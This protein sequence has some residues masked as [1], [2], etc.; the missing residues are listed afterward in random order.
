MTPT[1]ST[2]RPTGRPAGRGADRGTGRNVALGV[3]L[4][5]CAAAVVAHVAVLRTSGQD[6]VT[7]PIGLLSTAPAGAWHGAGI[8]AFALAHLAL[9]WLL[10]LRSTGPLRIAARVAL[11]LAA[12][13][14]CYVAAYFAFADPAAFA[15]PGADDRL[16]VPASLVG[17]AMGLLLPG[18]WRTHRR[19]AWFGG[20]CFAAWMALTAL[21][22]L[23]DPS[24]IGAYE[25]A[26]GAVYVTWVAGMA[27]LV[28]KGPPDA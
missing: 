9:A 27:V 23:V 22:L 21:V 6:P 25:R 16:P 14:L 10:G 15:G 1:T 5:G 12:G 3:A 4:A 20:A 13:A 26:V 2:A 7:T 19:A 18:L 11:V 28:A 24:W 8:V 17:F